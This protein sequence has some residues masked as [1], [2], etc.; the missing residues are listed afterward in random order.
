MDRQVLEPEKISAEIWTNFQKGDP[1][2]FSDIYYAF[3]QSMFSYGVCFT[4][5]RELVKDCI[6]E[7]FVKVYNFRQHLH[8]ENMKFYLIRALK[9][10][11]YNAFRN[12]KETCSIEES[13]GTF[14]PVYSVED[15]FIAKEQE[16]SINA[17]V[18]KML[19][20]L[21]PH[22]KEVIYYRYIKELSIK[23]IA[24]L[25]DMNYQSVQN[26]IQR[27][28]SKL[29]K[30]YSSKMIFLLFPCIFLN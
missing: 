2:A 28:I 25:M 20:S 22:Q 24:E 4:N 13:S 1:R 14:S 29:R 5:D 19:N 23:E 7:V 8:L 21:S 26:L 18:V 15:V 27:S 10:E 11:L 17:D 3:A 6:H 12:Q 16:N 9:N 30:E